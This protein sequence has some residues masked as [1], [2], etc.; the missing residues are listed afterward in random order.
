VKRLIALVVLAMWV[1]GCHVVFSDEPMGTV[2]RIDP[3]KWEGVW[4]RIDRPDVL[5]IHVVDA[6][7]GEL[8]LADGNPTETAPDE[9]RALVRS[10]GDWTYLNLACSDASCAPD[11]PATRYHWVVVD[12]SNDMLLIWE[13]DTATFASL[14][15]DGELPGETHGSNVQ[16]HALEPYHYDLIQSEDR[17]TPLHWRRPTVFRRSPNV[18]EAPAP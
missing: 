7:T 10:H 15:T 6:D 18:T 3:A 16:L 2:A 11:D 1:G 5:R 17:A 12:I 9:A 8:L 14:V 13:P 4:T